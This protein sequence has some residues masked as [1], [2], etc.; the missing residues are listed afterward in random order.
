[1]DKN[2][3]E[4]LDVIPKADYLYATKSDNERSLDPK[5]LKNKL[6]LNKKQIFDD[7]KNAFKSAKNLANKEDLV[8]VIG[9]AFLIGD[10]L[11]EF[12]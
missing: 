12:Y 3:D 7:Y 4:I 11:K 10:I 5:I 9:S 1:M 6:N 8:L 2:I